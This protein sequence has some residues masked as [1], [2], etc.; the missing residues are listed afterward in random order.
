MTIRWWITWNMA[1]KTYI[2]SPFFFHSHFSLLSLQGCH[3]LQLTRQT[4]FTWT[5][6]IK[7]K[8]HSN[9]STVPFCLTIL[10]SAH[11][12]VLIIVKT[13]SGPGWTFRRAGSIPLFDTPH[14]NCTNINSSNFWLPTEANKHTSSRRHAIKKS[15]WRFSSQLYLNRKCWGF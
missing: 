12:V 1:R 9:I 4:G 8:Q 6:L 5:V 7:K 15:S 13:S 11:P 14:L 3:H 10:P 2:I